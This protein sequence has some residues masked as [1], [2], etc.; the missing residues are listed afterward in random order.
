[1]IKNIINTTLS[2]LAIAACNFAI[3]IITTQI[4]GKEGRGIIALLVANVVIVSIFNNLMGGSTIAYHISRIKKDTIITVAFSWIIISSALVSIVIGQIQKDVMLFHLGMMALSTSLVQ[5]NL[6][7]FV[8][9]Q[10]IF[11]FN[12]FSFLK[13]FLSLLFLIFAIFVFRY[14]SL[15]VYFYT[16][17]LAHFL[18]FIA[19]L[20][21]IKPGLVAKLKSITET[22]KSLV[23]FGW[24]S[25][26]SYLIHFLNLRLTYFIVAHFLNIASVGILSVAMSLAENTWIISRSISL[27][28]FSK[29]VNTED[30]KENILHTNKSA[31]ISVG[32]T[33]FLVVVMLALPK[34]IYGFVFGEEF[35]EI[36]TYILYLSPG[37]VSLS[38]GTIYGHYFSGVKKLI[39]NNIKSVIGL[40]TL[41][42]SALILI[43]KLELIGVCIAA[44]ISYVLST[45]YLLIIYQREKKLYL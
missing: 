27:V 18:V 30:P 14:T 4:W 28:Q 45:S 8:G 17:Y 26:L 35:S 24:L 37:I 42:I 32:A 9:Q 40:V 25:E 44:S 20:F 5:A 39:H 13:S 31:W 36:K 21:L 7:V 33:S 43:P 3:V 16:F 15:E 1:M 6:Q 2:K 10:D 12:L 19:T 34:S 41:A 38:L 11:E 22:I 23:S 29:I